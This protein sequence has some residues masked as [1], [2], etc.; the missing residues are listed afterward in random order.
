MILLFQSRDFQKAYH[1]TMWV[2]STCDWE[3]VKRDYSAIDELQDSSFSLNEGRKE[4][5]HQFVHEIPKKSSLNESKIRQN[6]VKYICIFWIFQAQ[7]R[8]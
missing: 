4:I 3:I 6:F 1:C 7:V 5:R 8:S 2:M